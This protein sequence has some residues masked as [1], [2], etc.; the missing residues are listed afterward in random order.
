MEKTG[1]QQLLQSLQR[2]ASIAIQLF[3][4]HPPQASAHLD[5]KLKHFTVIIITKYSNTL[6]VWQENRGKQKRKQ[7]ACLVTV[8]KAVFC[9]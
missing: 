3:F 8:P 1:K 2:S 5:F 9:C 4:P 7:R 6:F